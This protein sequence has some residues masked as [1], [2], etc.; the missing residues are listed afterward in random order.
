MWIV[1]IYIRVLIVDSLVW[2]QRKTFIC[3]C[4]CSCFIVVLALDDCRV[5]VR[6]SRV[7]MVF[8]CRGACMYVSNPRN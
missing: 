1:L 3:N 4:N 2:M 5:G 6:Y 7:V 8:D